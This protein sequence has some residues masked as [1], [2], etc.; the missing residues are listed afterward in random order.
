[1]LLFEHFWKGITSFA[2]GIR[3]ITRKRFWYYLIL[4]GIINLIIF[5]ST[6]SFIFSYSS[7]FVEWVL[8]LIGM[9]DADSGFMGGL[10]K[11]LYF[12]LVFIIRVMYF[13]FYI[14]VY[15]Y[16][17]LILMAPLLAYI[18]EK[19]EEVLTGKTYDFELKQFLKDTW[20]GIAIA[21]RNFVFEMLFLIL[22]LAVGW[23][24][25]I[26]LA[27]PV[28][29][30]LV[31]SYFYGY[32]MFDYNN[33][34]KKMS[35]KEGSKFVWEHK[36]SAIANGALFHLM[37]LLPIVGWVVSPVLSV[38]SAGINYHRIEEEENFE[39]IAPH[40]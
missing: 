7:E 24:P 27:A 21:I 17:M 4:P 16:V 37:Y 18:S 29:M 34:R 31:Q 28:L 14:T 5:F 8:H 11:F 10:K 6:F 30:F 38:I 20:R 12:L 35:V 13:L 39:L 22:F 32:S 40:K 25:V 3:F 33:E 15:K 23:I 2:T 26:G 1:M 9:A 36:G 19:T